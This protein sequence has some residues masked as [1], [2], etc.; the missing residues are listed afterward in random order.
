MDYIYSFFGYDK[1]KTLEDVLFKLKFTKKILAR[2][3]KKCETRTNIETNK[4][5]EDIIKN[6]YI[7][8]QI[9]SENTIRQK[10]QRISFMRLS[11]RLDALVCRLEL[12]VQNGKLTDNIVNIAYGLESI[13]ENFTYR[14]VVGILS[15]FDTSFEDFDVTM[16]LMD[17][18]IEDTT[19]NQIPKED[20]IKLMQFVAD[21]HQLKIQ[22]QFMELDMYEIE[23]KKKA[24]IEEKKDELEERFE[25][26]RKE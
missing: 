9:H 20:V 2:D 10:N 11:S 26:L 7:A 21:T 14:N 19:S 4:I 23:T 5:K 24:S 12:A 25:I 8:A 16:N 22:E 15:R 13:Q 17:K 3:I 1:Y 6:D 18:S